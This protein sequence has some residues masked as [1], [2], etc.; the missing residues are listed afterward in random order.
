VENKLAQHPGATITM[1]NGQTMTAG[2]A[3]SI[4]QNTTYTITDQAPNQ[5]SAGANRAADGPGGDGTN[6]LV[7]FDLQGLIGY[8][9]SANNSNNQTIDEIILHEAAHDTAAGIA[10]TQTE[11]TAYLQANPSDTAGVHYEGSTQF[12]TNEQFTN[13][14]ASDIAYAAG[15]P[16]NSNP[17]DG[18]GSFPHH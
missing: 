16:V 2:Q 4:L 9:N 10:E 12:L 13:A 1:P 17:T 7:T 11:W 14:L 8:E 18:F 6:N 3:L 5:W 15:I